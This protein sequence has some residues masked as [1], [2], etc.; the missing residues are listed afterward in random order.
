MATLP[1]PPSR[2]CLL[3]TKHLSELFFRLGINSSC[4]VLEQRAS[5]CCPLQRLPRSPFGHRPSLLI[6]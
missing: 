6:V 1:P 5:R 3:T 4:G 2:P